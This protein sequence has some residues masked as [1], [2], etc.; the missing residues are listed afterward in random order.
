VASCDLAG[1]IPRGAFRLRIG[2]GQRT[3][4]GVD[5]P[6]HSPKLPVKGIIEH[7][8]WGRV[9][10]S[11]VRPGARAGEDHREVDRADLSDPIA[12]RSRAGGRPIRSPSGRTPSDAMIP[13]T[14]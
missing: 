13:R 4:P 3:V 9:F 1:Q 7:E 2:I 11:G 14:S 12:R 10:G 8:I 5:R 6:R